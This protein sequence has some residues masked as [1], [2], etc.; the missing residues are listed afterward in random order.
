MINS[1]LELKSWG[2]V[3]LIFNKPPRLITADNN[4][5]MFSKWN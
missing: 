5:V 3:I 2:N 1:W 4:K